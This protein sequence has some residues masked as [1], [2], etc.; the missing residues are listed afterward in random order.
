MW[1]KVVYLWGSTLRY[2]ISILQMRKLQ[3]IWVT[4]PRTWAGLPFLSLNPLSPVFSLIHTD[5]WKNIYFWLHQVL[6]VTCRTFCCSM[7][8]LVTVACGVNRPMACGLL[9]PQ[10]RTKAMSPAFKG[11]FLTIGPPEKSPTLTFTAFFKAVE[12]VSDFN[13]VDILNNWIKSLVL[14]LGT[15]KRH[16]WRAFTTKAWKENWSLEGK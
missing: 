8:S 10:P 12:S 11:G 16:S 5:L 4:C 1:L 2:I 13:T 6:V 14:L 15:D 3:R 9:V 7:G